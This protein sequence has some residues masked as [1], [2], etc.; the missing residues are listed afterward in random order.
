M[1]TVQVVDKLEE[2]DS[3]LG[4]ATYKVGD[5]TYHVGS[6]PNAHKITRE[7]FNSIDGWIN[8]TDTQCWFN[9]KVNSMWFPWDEGKHCPPEVFYAVIRTLYVWT[10]QKHLKTIYIHCDAGTHRAP[11]VFGAWLLAR[12]GRKDALKIVSQAALTKRECLSN[13]IEYID[14]HLHYIPEDFVLIRLT[15]QTVLNR[16]DGIL[17]TMEKRFKRRYLSDKDEYAI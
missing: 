6:R 17:H 12:Y 13:P 4:Y 10:E 16:Y 14:D 1:Y 2:K 7:F 11:T 5:I 15:A 8:V 9:E 3:I